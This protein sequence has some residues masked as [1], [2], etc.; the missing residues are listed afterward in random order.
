MKKKKKIENVKH[1]LFKIG[2]FGKYFKVP[3]LLYFVI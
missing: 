3:I 2:V 1:N